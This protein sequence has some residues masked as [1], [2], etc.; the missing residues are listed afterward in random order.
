MAETLTITMGDAVYL[1]YAVADSMRV[2][3]YN[4]RSGFYGYWCDFCNGNDFDVEA[5][6]GADGWPEVQHAEDCRGKRLLHLLA[7]AVQ[8]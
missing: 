7:P 8:K 6:L 5:P 4:E 1:Y 2:E 3:R